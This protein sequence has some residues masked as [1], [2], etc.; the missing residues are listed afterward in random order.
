MLDGVPFR[1]VL[2]CGDGAEKRGPTRCSVGTAVRWDNFW[3][4]SSTSSFLSPPVV[5]ASSVSFWTAVVVVGF[6]MF[7]VV[8]RITCVAGERGGKGEEDILQRDGSCS[9]EATGVKV[10]AGGGGIAVSCSNVSL[11]S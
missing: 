10:D 8:V 1:G 2:V 7:G 5:E 4:F 9:G 3:S 11:A 6:F